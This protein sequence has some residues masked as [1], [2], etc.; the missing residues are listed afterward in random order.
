[1]TSL[2]DPDSLASGVSGAGGRLIEVLEEGRRRRYL[3]PGPLEAQVAHARAFLRL[4]RAESD[5]PSLDLGSGGG[6]PGLVLALD[7]PCSRWVLVDA[8][9][10]KTAFL[11]WACLALGLLDRVSVVTGRAE[12]LGRDLA[13]RGH[14]STVVARSFARPPAVAEC[15]APLLRVGGVLLVSEPPEER[16]RWPVS[17]LEQ[18]GLVVLQTEPATPRI[19]ALEQQRLCPERFPR[20]GGVPAKRPLW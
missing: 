5:A 14:Y 12:E 19:V 20:R 7:R 1:M 9:A 8:N 3:G 13:H 10:R 2:A 18:L 15:A 17:G 6:L 4:W 16:Q 11:S